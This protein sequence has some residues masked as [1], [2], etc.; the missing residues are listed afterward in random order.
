MKWTHSWC[1]TSE[2]SGGIAEGNLT[3]LMIGITQDTNNYTLGPDSTSRLSYQYR[4]S[5]CG[6]KMIIR[7]SYLHNGI[8]YNGAMPYQLRKSHCGDKTILCSSISTMISP[9]PVRCH[10]DIEIGLWS[11]QTQRQLWQ[12]P[13]ITS[14]ITKDIGLRNNNLNSHWLFIMVTFIWNLLI[15]FSLLRYF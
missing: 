1:I 14:N 5:H 4:K 11:V 15:F 10:L 3:Q 12:A 13:N 9:K 2:L 7:S 8:S 6:D